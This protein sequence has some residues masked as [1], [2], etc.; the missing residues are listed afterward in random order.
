MKPVEVVIILTLLAKNINSLSDLCYTG[1]CPP[2]CYDII[3]WIYKLLKLI[4]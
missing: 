3:E 1:I 4:I 2:W